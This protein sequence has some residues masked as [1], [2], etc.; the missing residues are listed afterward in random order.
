MM[1]GRRGEERGGLPGDPASWHS[2]PRTTYG[3]FEGA[4]VEISVGRFRAHPRQ[5]L[6][7]LDALEEVLRV[8]D[9]FVATA[10]PMVVPRLYT[11]G[12]LLLP[13]T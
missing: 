13:P 3:A 10:D 12:R 9:F 4:V 5:R 8:A 11:K 2:I 1:G 6:V 7:V